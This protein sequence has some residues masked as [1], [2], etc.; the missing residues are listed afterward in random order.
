MIE[1]IEARFLDRGCSGEGRIDRC[2]R[3]QTSFQKDL[4]VGDTAHIAS[5]VAGLDA[6]AVG[7]GAGGEA[8][9]GEQQ[10]RGGR[11]HQNRK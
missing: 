6:A 11:A 10:E 7:V 4:E 5:R 8:A 9:V 2:R 3:E 1:R